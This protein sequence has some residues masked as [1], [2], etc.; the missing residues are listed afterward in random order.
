MIDIKNISKLARLELTPAEEKKFS[1][2]LSSILDYF[3]QLKEIKTDNVEPTA[4]VTGL[5]NITR[6]DKIDKERTKNAHDG[7]LENAP[8]RDDD[9]IEVKAVF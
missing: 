4:Q 7:I 1:K 3:E 2:E 9:H 8:K 6:E 5:E